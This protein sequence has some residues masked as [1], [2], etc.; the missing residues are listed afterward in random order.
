MR[1]IV[2]DG[3]AALAASQC[4]RT[5]RH[6][7]APWRRLPMQ[8]GEQERRVLRLHLAV[9]R[10]RARAQD[11]VLVVE[12]GQRV[13]VAQLVLRR[14]RVAVAGEDAL[15]VG[16]IARST[17]TIDVAADD[18]LGVDR[19]S[20]RPGWRAYRARAR[21]WVVGV[22]AEHGQRSGR[23][24][25]RSLAR[26][27]SSPSAG[28]PRSATT[29]RQQ[30]ARPG[31]GSAGNASSSSSRPAPRSPTRIAC[32]TASSRS[33]AEALDERRGSRRPARRPATTSFQ[34]SS[35]RL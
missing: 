17:A 26:R 34:A 8:R 2:F 16:V 10:Q 7:A 19:W 4:W 28:S 24:A 20:G 23:R 27:S 25:P 9:H 6:A 21:A 12:L 14:R 29:G 31:P 5:K 33:A 30:R 35:T 1:T 18:Q 22:V 32:Q 11:Q 3:K 15:V 13:E